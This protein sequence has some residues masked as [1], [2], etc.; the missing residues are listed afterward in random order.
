MA[1]EIGKEKSCISKYILMNN[2]LSY[3]KISIRETD[4]SNVSSLTILNLISQHEIIFSSPLK[5]ECVI[6]W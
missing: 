1:S 4:N 5:V 3:M 2:A 6:F